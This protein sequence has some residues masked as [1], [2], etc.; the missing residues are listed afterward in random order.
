MTSCGPVR[1]TPD[2]SEEKI[3]MPERRN[4]FVITGGPGAGKTSIVER[5]AARGF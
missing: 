4:F 3:R 2:Y 5:L 1:R